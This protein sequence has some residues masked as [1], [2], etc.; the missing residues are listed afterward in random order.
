MVFTKPF[1]CKS[2]HKKGNVEANVGY[3]RRNLFVPIVALPGDV[4]HYNRTRLFELCEKLMAER[5]HYI[6]GCPVNDL[7]VRDQDTLQELP[8]TPF[9]AKRLLRQQTNGYGEIILDKKHRY[10]LDSTLRNTQ[11]LV[12][13]YPWKVKFYNLSGT[14]LEEYPRMYGDDVT[15]SINI[16]TSIRNVMKKP[17]SWHNSMLREHMS[18]DNPL[19]TYLDAAKD[20]SIIKKALYRFSDAMETFSYDTVLLAFQELL[21]RRMDVTNKYNLYACC[22]RVET[23]DPRKSQ[24]S[25]GVSLDKYAILMGHS[26]RNEGGLR[27]HQ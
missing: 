11:L 10:A 27:A 9:I 8:H 13:T 3:L 19:K 12:E 15:D 7:F 25:T 1:L 20:T 18:Q 24:N 4:E 16:A 2:L 26:D 14:L 21:D 22:N 5:L 17:N 6:H 23:F